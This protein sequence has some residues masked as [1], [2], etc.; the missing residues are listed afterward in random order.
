[1]AE[2]WHQHGGT[3]RTELEI[4]CRNKSLIRLFKLLMDTIKTWINSPAPSIFLKWR[5]CIISDMIRTVLCLESVKSEA[6]QDHREVLGIN[7]IFTKNLLFADN[8]VAHPSLFVVWGNNT[9]SLPLIAFTKT[10]LANNWRMFYSCMKKGFKILTKWFK[11]CSV[12]P[13][14]GLSLARWEK[15]IAKTCFMQLS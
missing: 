14:T 5:N 12:L 1:M 6:E 9:K 8:N 10:L 13:C 15:A 4:K 11:D 2:H 7:R 3:L